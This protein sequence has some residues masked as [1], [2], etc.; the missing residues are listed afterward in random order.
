[1]IRVAL[2][3]F[4]IAIVAACSL[5][6]D[7]G[8]LMAGACDSADSRPATSVSFGTDIRPLIS[9]SMGHCG[10]HLQSSGGPGPG[11]QLSGL[12][13]SSFTTLRE[14][15]FN[16]GERIVVA[17]DPCA[18]ILYQKL[19]VSPPFGSRMPLNGPPFLDDDQLRLVH[20]WIAEGAKDN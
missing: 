18:S 17:G 1:V 16:S 9:G 11:V 10:C 8:P 7:V 20:D 14:G 15:G 2:G 6:P 13:L 12:D 19:S 5:T 4:G 3:G